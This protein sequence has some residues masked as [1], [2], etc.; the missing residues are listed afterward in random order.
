[1]SAG[2]LEEEAVSFVQNNCLQVFTLFWIESSMY[3]SAT[4]VDFQPP[5]LFIAAKSAPESDN[6]EAE[7]LRKQCPVYRCG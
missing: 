4:L 6:I 1:M 3:A 2:G 5:S 7:D